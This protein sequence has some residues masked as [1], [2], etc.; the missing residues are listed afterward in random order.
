MKWTGILPLVALI[1]VGCGSEKGN[2]SAWR[3][4]AVLTKGAADPRAEAPQGSV[5]EWAGHRWH[6]L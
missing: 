5:G 2:D 3:P 4:S 1:A 6:S